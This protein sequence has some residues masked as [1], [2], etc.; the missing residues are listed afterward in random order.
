MGHN[1]DGRNL[2]PRNSIQKSMEDV[3]PQ[4]P[5]NDK[6]SETQIREKYNV[7]YLKAT[8]MTAAAEL[9]IAA[10]E[11]LVI[12]EIVRCGA[13]TEAL[14]TEMVI[15]A[16]LQVKKAQLERS[17]DALVSIDD[18]TDESD[19]LSDL[20]DLTMSDVYEDVGLSHCIPFD[21]CTCGSAVSLVKETPLYEKQHECVNLCDP[22]KLGAQQLKFD[23]MSAR[24]QI[25]EKMVMD[26][27]KDNVPAKSFNHGREELYDNL[28]PCLSN[29]NVARHNDSALKNS[30]VLTKKQEVS[31]V[32]HMV[33]DTRSIVNCFAAETSFPS[34]SADIAPDMNSVVQ[35][36]EN[37]LHR[38]SQSTIHFDLLPTESNKGILHSQDVVMSSS[39]SLVD[40][41]CSVVPCSFPSEN[42]VPTS[43]QTQRDKESCTEKC[44]S[45]TT[46]LG[47]WNSHKP[48]NLGFE[49]HHED[50]QATAAINGE[51]SPVTVRRQFISLKTYSTLLPNPISNG[52]SL[53]QSIEL[54]CAQRLITLDQNVGCN[55]SSYRH[56]K[57]SLP[58][59]HL[60]EH[61]SSRD[62]TED[63]K[64][65]SNGCPDKIKY[66]ETTG[67]GNEF[68]DQASIN[69]RE[70]HPKP[71]LV[72]DNVVEFQQNKKLQCILSECKSI[73]GR[74]VPAKKRVHFSEAEIPVQLMKNPKILD[75]ST[76]NWLTS[77]RASKKPKCSNYSKFQ[78]HEKCWRTNPH[79]E[80][81][82][83]LLFHGIQFLLT[84]F[85]W[86][87]EK[88]LE[89]Q[90][91]KHG[92]I[93]LFDIPSPIS[94]ANRSLRSNG[95][96][97]P[98]ILWRVMFFSDMF[99]LLIATKFLYGCA[100]NAF[101]LNDDWLTNSISAD[102][103]VPPEQYIILHNVAAAEHIS[104]GKPFCY[105]H[106]YVFN[107]H[108]GGQVFK[109]IQRLML[110][111]GKEKISWGAIV[112]EDKNTS[113]H[114][115]HCAAEQR[116]PIMPASWII[117]SLHLGKRL[118]F[119]EKC[120]S[121]SSVLTI[122]G[123]TSHRM[124]EDV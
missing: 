83:R 17:V 20:D 62:N 75:I 35:V 72:V 68:P 11:A 40:P 90:I 34:E 115:R 27:L 16:A 114:L 32:G 69:K 100:V 124:S 49:F 56:G 116:I 39:L 33:R 51:D 60:S 42:E 26:R 104:I 37:E 78:N 10:S 110:D 111:L 9:S 87:K 96:Q 29:C 30:T 105:R 108:G 50:C 47:M 102:H 43:A 41:L 55:R 77:D 46:E 63:G 89:G 103:I 80:A 82:K 48:S 92:G 1:L 15:E 13:V 8:D 113:R 18:E 2:L 36:H 84:G 64:L 81:E 25:S 117:K 7:K 24:G 3:G 86:Q 66:N 76:K 91:W 22:V 121:S 45:P 70:K 65:I 71:A 31:A 67:D 97:L 21:D 99:Y 58:F 12:H 109:T 74:D 118:P 44:S 14:P 52:G 5:S 85:S 93:V 98:I 101:I 38:M 6:I 88:D 4:C 112:S 107:R 54:D 95:Y 59:K 28:V 119:A 61:L 106:D 53:Y 57:A 73:H 23:D 79:V 19:S 120:H 94:R 122:S 123:P